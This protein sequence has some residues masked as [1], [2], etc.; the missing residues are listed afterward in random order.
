[1]LTAKL[2][3]KMATDTAKTFFTSA[4]F[5]VVGAS[6]DPSKFGHKSTYTS[7]FL[8][9]LPLLSFPRKL[10]TS[11]VFAWYLREGLPVTP[12]NPSSTTITALNS[13]YPTLPNLSAL[14]NP[15]ETG[16]SIITPPK[17]T[18][19]VLEEAKKLGIQAVWLQPGTFDDEILE[20]AKSEFKAGVGGNGG[21]GSEGWCVLVDGERAARAAGKKLKL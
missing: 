9:L 10:K 15:T 6:S 1:M 3:A 16:V 19:K 4:H 7:S 5:A 18:K 13:S 11:S 20:Y 12:I 21:D 8:P 2:T 17:V 14:P